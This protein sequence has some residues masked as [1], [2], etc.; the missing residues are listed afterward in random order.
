[1]NWPPFC[2]RLGPVSLVTLGC[3]H[4]FVSPAGQTTIA[5]RPVSNKRTRG[6]TRIWGWPGRAGKIG[7]SAGLEVKITL[8]NVQPG[9]PFCSWTNL[10]T[11][12]VFG[13][14][15]AIAGEPEFASSRGRYH[16]VV[17]AELSLFA[18]IRHLRVFASVG[19]KVAAPSVSAEEVHSI[20]AEPRDSRE[21][22]PALGATTTEPGTGIARG[23]TIWPGRIET[24][25]S[26][27][28]G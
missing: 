5:S 23:K 22:L 10:A 4:L 11:E 28:S 6:R 14:R 9:Q 21:Q 16:Y 12:V 18:W 17:L 15:D 7:P 19:N 3:K 26:P 27:D 25:N 20:V 1:M 13:S 24:G 8:P 2:S